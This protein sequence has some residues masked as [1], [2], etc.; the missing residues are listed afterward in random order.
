MQRR[1]SQK[2]LIGRDG[3]HYLNGFHRMHDIRKALAA[4]LT[5]VVRLN[6]K[7]NRPIKQAC[8]HEFI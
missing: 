4:P 2:A 7:N 3:S 5:V 1:G 8:I 6:R